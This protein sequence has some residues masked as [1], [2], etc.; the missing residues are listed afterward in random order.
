MAAKCFGSGQ[1]VVAFGES[2]MDCGPCGNGTEAKKS[3]DEFASCIF[4]ACV[5]IV[6]ACNSGDVA[7]GGEKHLVVR[8][9]GRQTGHDVRVKNED[10][11]PRQRT[12]WLRTVNPALVKS[13]CSACNS[14]FNVAMIGEQH[15]VRGNSAVTSNNSLEMSVALDDNFFIN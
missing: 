4:D 2:R 11:K 13:P 5:G 10:F 3:G 8:Y 14:T 12:R 7:S 6:K 1:S 9:S 15:P